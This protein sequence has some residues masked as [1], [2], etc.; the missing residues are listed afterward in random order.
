MNS[1]YESLHQTKPAQKVIK[2][3][4]KEI[5]LSYKSRGCE[6]DAETNSIINKKAT[7]GYIKN[8]NAKNKLSKSYSQPGANVS[9]NPNGTQ[10]KRNK[11]KN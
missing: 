4:A 6:D 10:T 8:A 7:S 2:Q 1:K 5:R 11:S 3:N 9:S